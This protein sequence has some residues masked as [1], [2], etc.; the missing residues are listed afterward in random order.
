[1]MSDTDTK[2]LCDR[3]LARWR[4]TSETRIPDPDA[5]ARLIAR[6]GVATLYPVSPELP[7]LFHAYVGDPDRG[8][9]SGWDTPSGEVYAWRW[10]LGRQEAAFYTAIVRGRPTWVYWDLLPAVIR[11]CGELRMPDELYDVGAISGDA[12]RVAQALEES[13]GVLGT[14]ELRKRAGFPTGKEQRAAYLRA[15]HE[16]DTRLLLAKV[17]DE[18]DED[19]RHALV[20]ERYPRHVAAAEALTREEALDLLLAAYLPHA[21]Y[22]APTPLAKVL[23]IPEAELR[24]GLERAVAGGT[25]VAVTLPGNKGLCYVWRE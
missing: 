13:G 14:G 22:A 3:R 8:T 16:L 1:M 11:L 25:A 6:V 19:M 10:A 24:A 18:N 20:R 23:K 15:V 4:Q 21:V 9:D 2:A 17:F 12:Y 5:A 7:N